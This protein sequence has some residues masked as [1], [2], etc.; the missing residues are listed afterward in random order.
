MKKL[1]MI[2]CL[3]VLAVT[4][5]GQNTGGE[6]A[7]P[8][9]AATTAVEAAPTETEAGYPSPAATLYVPPTP[10]SYPG[11]ETGQPT[12]QPFSVPTASATAGVVTGQLI[13]VET[14][15]PLAFQSVYLGQKIPFKTG[16][17]YTYGL[18]EQSSPHTISNSEGKFA[19]GDVPADEYILILFTPHS[20]SVVHM[21]GADDTKELDVIVQAG[22]VLD[23][24][25]LKAV[26]P[27]K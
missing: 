3:L 4:G 12:E 6:T 7:Q 20:I 5:C 15:E 13:N 1:L 2:A 10:Q 17:G 23:L 22:Q 26:S 25:Q 19:I 8:T 16:T 21:Q 18:Q 24:G 14:G 27:I 11:A 9:M